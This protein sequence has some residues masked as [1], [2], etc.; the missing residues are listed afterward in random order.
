MSKSAKNIE[1]FL[2]YSNFHV[3]IFYFASPC[4]AAKKRSASVAVAPPTLSEL[5]SL[6]SVLSHVLLPKQVR[7]NR[8]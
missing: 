8:G 6:Y 7:A 4:M 5:S 3:G 1:A 2:R